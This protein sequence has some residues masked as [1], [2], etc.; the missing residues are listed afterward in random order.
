[1]LLEEY[2]VLHS[3]IETYGRRAQTEKA[4]EEFAELIAALSRLTCLIETAAGSDAVQAGWNAVCEELADAEV[5]LAQM[6]IIYDG[7]ATE[8]IRAAKLRRL[9]KRLG[10]VE[11]ADKPG[12]WGGWKDPAE[13]P[14]TGKPV[15]AKYI[16]MNGGEACNDLI[17]E[18]NGE[19]WIYHDDPCNE[20]GGMVVGVKL[21]GWTELPGSES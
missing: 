3:A 16:P 9:A 1:M 5:M 8:G 6:R 14:A 19:D 13:H 10:L 21:L 4:C 12:G 7:G 17:V 2:T 18:W 11:R 20:D 15:L